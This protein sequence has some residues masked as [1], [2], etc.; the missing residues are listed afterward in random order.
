MSDEGIKSGK[1]KILICLLYYVPHRTGL[2]LHVQRV[3]EE[4]G[5]ARARRYG[6]DSSL[7]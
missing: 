1:L 4:L 2:T 6:P 5:A 3:A 7:Q